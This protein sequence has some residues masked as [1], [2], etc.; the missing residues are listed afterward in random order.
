MWS[1]IILTIAFILG[2]FAGVAL[3][4]GKVSSLQDQL[5]MRCSDCPDRKRVKTLEAE[6]IDLIKQNNVYRIQNGFL[7]KR[8]VR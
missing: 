4:R 1:Y 7:K 5:N 8:M 3:T 6:N 2:F